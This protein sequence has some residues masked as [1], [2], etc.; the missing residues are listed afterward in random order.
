METQDKDLLLKDLCARLPYGVNMHIKYYDLQGDGE[1]ASRDVKLTTD[2]ICYCFD[3]G[4]WV[5]FKL[6]LRPMSSMTEEEAIEFV[7]LYGVEDFL[8]V[9]VT[10]ECLEIIIDDELIPV[11]KLLYEDIH[12]PVECF[13]FLLRNH[14]DFRNLIPMGL[15]LP[16]PDGMYDFK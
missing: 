2:N 6:Y 14:F 15:A 10:Q 16:A 13:D 3:N 8:K 11:M 1:L 5:D 12:L 9:N 4:H 7:S